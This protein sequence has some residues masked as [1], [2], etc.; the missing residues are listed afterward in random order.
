MN[1]EVCPKSL[2]NLADKALDLLPFQNEISTSAIKT[3]KAIGN[4]QNTVSVKI[5]YDL[6]M[7]L[8]KLKSTVSEIF[9]VVSFNIINISLYQQFLQRPYFIRCVKP[10]CQQLPDVYDDNFVR[11]QLET[12]G[13]LAYYNFI[14]C[15]Y[16]I[17][18]SISELFQKLQEILDPRY[19]TFGEVIC[20]RIFLLANNISLKNFKFG[21]SEIHIRRGHEFPSTFDLEKINDEFNCFLRRIRILKLRIRFLGQRMQILVLY[22]VIFKLKIYRYLN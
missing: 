18:I 7:L 15:S 14:Q 17:K 3:T 9:I 2:K 22:V 4:K 1:C 6:N 13:T 21:K 19:I 16:P 8:S 5:R 12:S 20:C 11:N 10:N